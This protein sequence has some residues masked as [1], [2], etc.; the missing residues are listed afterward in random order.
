MFIRPHGS[1][2]TLYKTPRFNQKELK[3]SLP[4]RTSAMVEEEIDTETPIETLQNELS[5]QLKNKQRAGAGHR[6]ALHS[7]GKL[8]EDVFEQALS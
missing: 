4:L 8:Q 7:E 5:V 1:P 6:I 3:Q 2:P